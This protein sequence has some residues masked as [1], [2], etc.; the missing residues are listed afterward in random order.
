MTNWITKENL[1]KNSVI[2]ML[3][4]WGFTRNQEYKEELNLFEKNNMNFWVSDEGIL[5]SN[6]TK[7]SFSAFF[8]LIDSISIGYRKGK[9]R[10]VNVYI[11]FTGNKIGSNC[12]FASN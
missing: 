4:D 7:Y 1:N 6:G 11:S 9:N 8:T 10:D 5:I 2:E 12:Q 3:K